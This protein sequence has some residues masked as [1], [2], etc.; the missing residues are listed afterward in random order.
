MPANPRLAGVQQL[1]SVVLVLAV[2][3]LDRL[4]PVGQLERVNITL[5]GYFYINALLGQR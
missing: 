4:V 1:R 5:T 3:D 2:D